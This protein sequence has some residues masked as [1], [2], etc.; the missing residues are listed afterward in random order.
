MKT[1]TVV[2]RKT[3]H[4]HRVSTQMTAETRKVIC[5]FTMN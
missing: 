5:V 4:L 3:Q 2:T 1:Q